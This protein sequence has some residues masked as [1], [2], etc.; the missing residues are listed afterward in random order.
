MALVGVMLLALAV[1]P[2]R[3][4]APS[5]VDAQ[6]AGSADLSIALF[7]WPDPVFPGN[8]LKYRAIVTNHGPDEATDVTVTGTLPAGVTYDVAFSDPRCSETGGIVTCALGSIA[9]GAQASVDAGAVV[10]PTLPAWTNLYY[11]VEAGAAQQDP[12]MGNNASTVRTRTAPSSDLSIALF[13]W[14]DPVQP[15]GLL[16]YKA[17][18]ENHGPADATGVA[19]VSA[20]PAGVVYEASVSDPRC[21]EASGTVTCD[22]GALA[23][24]AQATVDIMARVDLGIGPDLDMYHRMEVR[25]TQKDPDN[26][27]NAAIVGTRTAPAAD[28]A[29]VALAVFDWPDPVGAGGT[30]HY[31]AV[32]TNLGA[33]D[34]PWVT[35]MGTAPAEGRFD[36]ARSDSRCS[37]IG[38]T[39]TCNA[40]GLSAG[41]TI[42]LDMVFLVDAAT[43]PGTALEFAASVGGSGPVVKVR[44]VVAAA[45][46]P[47][48][49]APGGLLTN[50][51][52]QA[53]GAGKGNP[54]K[55]AWNDKPAKAKGTIAS[56]TGDQVTVLTS[57]GE[58]VTVTVN[59]D[60]QIKTDEDKAGY[61]SD[62]KPGAKVKVKYDSYKGIALK[63]DVEERDDD[64]DE[65]GD[66][67]EDE[68]DDEDED[69]DDD[70]DD[71]ED[72]D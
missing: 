10:D 45:A 66:D 27:N 8:L 60:T 42:E 25:G 31:R 30:L 29:D 67:D 40:G 9:A 2:L 5:G 26:S 12:D 3:G 32:M 56:I 38:V 17:I 33:G 72:E 6:A 69:D 48:F 70:E 46:V 14:P 63:I 50:T 23:S 16:H 18:F 44:T 57:R 47:Q 28:A 35:L 71:D 61:P 52:G 43:A 55:P 51:P 19:A 62:L 11:Q 53:V 41:G 34:A 7:D 54:V 37:I 49:A 65:D 22:I 1:G 4:I 59:D 20:L 24:G 68:G 36:A 15:G 21:L 13:D 64:E 58:L 39:V